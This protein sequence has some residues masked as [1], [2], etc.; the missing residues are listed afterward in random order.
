MNDNLFTTKLNMEFEN[1]NKNTTILNRISK[2]MVEAVD[3]EQHLIEE[4]KKTRRI[5]ALL[6]QKHARKALKNNPDNNNSFD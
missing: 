1:K 3:Y 2:E 5:K 6:F 4:F